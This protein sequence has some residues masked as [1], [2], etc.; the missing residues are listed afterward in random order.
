VILALA[1]GVG[2]AKLAQGLARVLAPED[3]TVVV[4]TGDDFEH[5]GLA[6]SPDLDTV[7]YT[8]AGLNDRERGWGLAGET[9]AFMAA[10]QRL[11]GP[12][13]FNL[14]DHDLATHIVRSARLGA[15]ESLSAVTEALCQG[16]GVKHPLVPMTDDRVRTKVDTDGGTLAFQEYFVRER[17]APVARRVWFEGI[18][19]ARPSESFHATLRSQRLRAV[20]LCPSNPFLSIAPI[21]A[22]PGVASLIDGAKVPVVAVSPIV[23]GAAI[24]GPAGK[25]LAE[26][27]H[28]VSVLGVARYYGNHVSTWIIDERDRAVQ[29]Q[30]EALGKRVLVTNTIMTTP[31][32]AADLAQT[33]LSLIPNS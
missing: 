28:E 19:R 11:G 27:G 24:K 32:A 6:V 18:E 3:L 31:E 7:M 9:W 5:L 20:V 10:L 15:G 29:A 12:S 4:N 25:L 14:G 2:G 33:I 13:W 1:G 16:L 23:G 26:L 30:L 8:L 17:C 22:L 21:L